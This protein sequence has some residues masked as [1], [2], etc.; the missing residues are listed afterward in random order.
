MTALSI[1]KI[2]INTKLP[3]EST[4]CDAM[5]YILEHHANNEEVIASIVINGKELDAYEENQC[6][7]MNMFSFNSIDFKLRS[8]LDMAYLSL[9]SCVGYID[10]VID[11]IRETLD[12]YSEN[13]VQ[14]ANILFSDVIE[15]MDLFIQLMSRIHKTIRRYHP[16]FF[17]NNKTLQQLEIHLLSVMK[18]LIPAKEKNDIIMLSDLLEYELIDNLTQWKIKAIPELKKT[19]EV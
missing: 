3:K 17:S 18:A 2:Q 7:G 4:V 9:D 5:D 12:L 11:K 8:S 14:E 1:N 6:L 13:K 19:Q 16:H 15:V 10:N